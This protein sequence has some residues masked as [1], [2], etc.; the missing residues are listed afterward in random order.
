[1]TSFREAQLLPP[2]LS[3]APLR[4]TFCF[5][6]SIFK[7]PF[8]LRWCCSVVGGAC[9]LSSS[10]APSSAALPS[11]LVTCLCRCP[12]F[13][14][15]CVHVTCWKINNNKKAA[16]R[17][18]TKTPTQWRQRECEGGRWEGNKYTRD[19]IKCVLIKARVSK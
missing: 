9:S 10:P 14:L 12:A 6:F 16:R 11:S 8:A 13:I 3:P 7:C 17:K 2:A 19:P 4:S 5:S 18:R 1:M 15:F